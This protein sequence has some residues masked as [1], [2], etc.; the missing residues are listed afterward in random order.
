MNTHIKIRNNIFETNSSSTHTLVFHRTEPTNV[1]DDTPLEIHGGYYGR[2]P[3]Y[4]LGGLEE[5]LN[6]LWQ[7]IWDNNISYDYSNSNKIEKNVDRK[8]L[9]TW[10][11]AIHLYCPNVILYDIKDDTWNGIDHSGELVPLLEAM[12]RNTFVLKDFLL[13]E[14]GYIIITGDEYEANEE[15]QF[16]DPDEIPRVNSWEDQ[17]KLLYYQDEKN[18]FTYLYEKGC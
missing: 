5:K 14:D 1:I 10:K 6:Y 3:T 12:K 9:N 17:D 7:A 4:P 2:C 18:R 11:D 8:S 13:D 16:F 15:K